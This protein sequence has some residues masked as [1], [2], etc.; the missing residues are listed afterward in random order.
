MLLGLIQ[1]C[2]HHIVIDSETLQ[3]KVFREEGFKNPKALELYRLYGRVHR[4]FNKMEIRSNKEI[5][6]YWSNAY[7][8][9]E[10]LQELLEKKFSKLEWKLGENDLKSMRDKLYEYFKADML[11]VSNFDAKGALVSDRMCTGIS[12]RISR[13]FLVSY[14]DII[15]DPTVD[16]LWDRYL[17]IARR[18][19]RQGAEEL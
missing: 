8:N 11:K 13:D 14:G 12:N 7:E 9:Q 17:S 6:E 4:N 10:L 3:F 5:A 1:A 18:N 15:G 2:T 16:A 19:I